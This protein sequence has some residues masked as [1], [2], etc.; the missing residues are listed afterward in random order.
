MRKAGVPVK[1]GCDIPFGIRA[2]QS[3]IEVDGIW[4]SQPVSPSLKSSNKLASTTTL[5]ALDASDPSKKG[6]HLSDDMKSVSIST[7][8]SRPLRRHSPSSGTMFQR[9]N[10]ADSVHSSQSIG[11]HGSQFAAPKPRHPRLAGALNEDALRRLEGHGVGRSS[12]ETYIPTSTFTRNPRRPSQRSLGSSSSGES[13]DSLPRS[14]RSASQ[15]SYQSSRASRLYYTRNAYEARHDHHPERET[16]DPFETPGSHTPI[17]PI[18]RPGS[19]S[20]NSPVFPSYDIANPEPTFGPGDVHVN[21]TTRRVNQG[22]EVLP[23][24]TFGI[25]HELRT[26]NNNADGERRA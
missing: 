12:V 5:V 18:V 3:G 14:G 25:P 19:H 21:R 4:I 15:M 24:G 6:K 23:A 17:S 20:P 13:V 10:D 7:A 11:P 26:N 16:R 22:F 2:I 1:R 9:L 8:D